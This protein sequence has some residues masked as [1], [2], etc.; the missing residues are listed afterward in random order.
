MEIQTLIKCRE[1][2][3]VVV[4]LHGDEVYVSVFVKGGHACCFMSRQEAMELIT[5]LQ[6]A[7]VNMEAAK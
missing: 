4:D 7:L 5:A 3:G 1:D 2:K 6:I